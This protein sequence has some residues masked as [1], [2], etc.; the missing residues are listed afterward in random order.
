[1][2]PFAR[3]AAALPLCLVALFAAPATAEPTEV[4]RF[5][6]A[7][8]DAADAAGYAESTLAKLVTLTGPERVTAAW[9]RYRR[10][11][12]RQITDP[13]LEEG[14]NTALDLLAAGRDGPFVARVVIDRDALADAMANEAA[15]GLEH[16]FAAELSWSPADPAARATLAARLQGVLDELPDAP[17]R[18][19]SQGDAVRLRIATEAGAGL[20]DAP[21]A[22]AGS[23][24]DADPADLIRFDADL[25][26]LG[27]LLDVLAARDDSPPELGRVFDALALDQIRAVSWAA[28]FAGADWFSRLHVD[29][30]A[31]A[32]GPDAGTRRGVAT[33]FE[34]AL[35]AEDLALVPVGT[36]LLQGLS[37]D[38]A[39]LLPLARDVAAAIGP[40]AADTL[41][42]GLAK[43]DAFLGAR[44]EDDLLGA[45]GPGHL[46]FVDPA[47]A[48][49]SAFGLRA[50]N[51]LRNPEGFT[52]ALTN[53]QNAAGGLIAMATTDQPVTVVV[54]TQ[55]R[56]GLL[57][58]TVALPAV[59]PTWAVK[60]GVLHVGLYPQS[61]L[62]LDPVEKDA[63][64]A[65]AGAGGAFVA[66]LP[67]NVRAKLGDGPWASVSFA[68]L[69]Q[70]APDSYGGLLLFE[71]L[72]TG[73]GAMWLREPF[74]A[75][76]P[77]YR[78][79][80]PLLGPVASV[81]RVT[82]AGLTVEAVSPFPGAGMLAGGGG[83]GA[84][85]LVQTIGTGIGAAAPAK[86]PN[87]G[88]ASGPAGGRGPAR[89]EWMEDEFFDVPP[90]PDAP[91]PPA[92]PR[93]PR[94]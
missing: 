4:L 80:A 57:L 9:S 36:T 21:A 16:R 11:I 8:T 13:D 14:V 42:D 53:L 91:E 10:L 28:G 56:N 41:E 61:L 3:A 92:T 25:A 46:L 32:D 51:R 20:L 38:P 44:V 55:S 86:D 94:S 30:P 81:G 34:N 71:S 64:A 26:L 6:W 72:F 12:D 52:K 78:D 29:A 47:V 90:A 37:F 23:G 58:N 50:T 27:D 87:R 69:P 39:R 76:L 65:P 84:A 62:A 40:E 22:A 68:D 73:G 82:D 1:M 67:A 5:R 79:V 74:P 45:L 31:V 17:A 63:A 15:D 89:P 7:G 66:G 19:V 24:A 70:T 54:H 75:V 60:D 35:T 83:G 33:L 48:G 85:V 59:S 2:N 93:A 88:P 18:L 77:P 43:A 49:R